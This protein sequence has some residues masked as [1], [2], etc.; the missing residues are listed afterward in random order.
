[1]WIEITLN[2]QFW[3]A[4]FEHNQIANTNFTKLTSEKQDLSKF[5]CVSLGTPVLGTRLS[6]VAMSPIEKD[7]GRYGSQLFLVCMFQAK[8]ESQIVENASC[9]PANVRGFD[10]SQIKISAVF[11]K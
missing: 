5:V 11:I 1:M 9:S 4:Q 3:L 8:C 10:D 2:A 6:L 7:F